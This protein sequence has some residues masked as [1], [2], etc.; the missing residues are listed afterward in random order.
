MR[1]KQKILL[2]G[3]VIA[4]SLAAFNAIAQVKTQRMI[5]ML[6]DDQVARQVVRSG[7]R[8]DSVFVD[9]RYQKNPKLWSAV[10][11]P[12]ALL[13]R[14]LENQHGARAEVAF[15]AYT[16]G[17]AAELN[18]QQ[19]LS[20]KADPRVKSVFPDATGALASGPPPWTNAPSVSYASTWT[21]GWNISSIS[22]DTASSSYRTDGGYPVKA[23]ILDSG[24]QPHYDLNY[25]PGTS[26]WSFDTHG[27]PDP[28]GNACSAH[29][30]HV[31]GIIGAYRSPA[32]T[33]VEGVAP[34]AVI[35]SMRIVNYCQVDNKFSGLVYLS[36][37][38]TAI[39]AIEGQTGIAKEPNA[40]LQRLRA[41]ANMSVLWDA[42]GGELFIDLAGRDALRAT[43][44]TAVEN[45]VFFSVAGG[46][47]YQ[48]AKYFYPAAV[49]CALYEWDDPS[50]T[51][52]PALGG[53]MGVG[54]IQWTGAP[55]NRDA[56]DPGKIASYGGCVKIWAPGQSVHS[57]VA[58]V[59]PINTYPAPPSSTPA[60]Y[61][62]FKEM[63]FWNPWGGT[64]AAPHNNL[65][66]NYFDEMSGSSM[67]A[68]HIAGAALL[69]A[70]KR[71]SLGQ[72]LPYPWEVENFLLSRSTAIGPNYGP[73]GESA[74]VN[75]IN[76]SGW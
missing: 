41:V 32:Q 65:G 12:A 1:M 54:A 26:S 44:K 43:M 38:L 76:V 71:Q 39:N 63:D 45:G 11:L 59:T 49:G 27:N 19:I 56:Y 62:L 37:V 53:V 75:L 69:F 30:T 47:S 60:P 18:E 31:A 61:P 13:V 35:W 14:D 2:V 64:S 52:R 16:N 57:T 7:E 6:N 36:S 72:P 48:N 29:A 46:N 51:L 42:K 17:F 23:F 28:Y 58:Q 25:D 20:L 3:V 4:T 50:H 9:Q 24:V 74:P 55:M 73:P 34:G 66:Q 22:A 21:R 68:P 15:G 67:A 40:P 70:K 33:G 8:I 10:S 5:V